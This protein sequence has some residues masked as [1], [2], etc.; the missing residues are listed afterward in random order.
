[1]MIYVEEGGEVEQARILAARLRIPLRLD[2]S[3]EPGMP[4]TPEEPEYK[5]DPCDG[6]DLPDKTEDLILRFHRGGISL[7]EGNLEMQGD[8]THM[9]P[10]LRRNNLQREFLVKASRLK[11]PGDSPVAIDATAGMGEDSVLL[12][13]AGYTVY[14]YEHNPVIAALLKDSLRRAS[15]VSELKEA[16]GRM[17]VREEDSIQGLSKQ[18]ITPDLILL[19]PMFPERKKSGLIKKKFQLLQKLEKPCFDEES[20]FEAAWNAN[21][22]KL[23]IKRPLKGP[24]LAGR[25]PDYSI[26]GRAIRYDCYHV[27]NPA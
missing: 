24:Y 12:A 6:T 7:M 18:D 21:P 13:A 1:M 17:H 11:H 2:A 20:L 14:L 25:K 22:R 10:R 9:I 5:A 15:E 26:P 4:G 3:P 19:D 8:L 27:M 23:V 16:V